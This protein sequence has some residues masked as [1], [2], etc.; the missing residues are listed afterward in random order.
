MLEIIN[1]EWGLLDCY[2]EKDN[3]KKDWKNRRLS[4]QIHPWIKNSKKYSGRS[5]LL[6]KGMIISK[7]WKFLQGKLEQV[8][9]L[10]SPPIK[11][12]WLHSSH[13]QAE[14]LNVSILDEEQIFFY[15]FQR[16]DFR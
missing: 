5:K 15:H 9:F 3:E 7:W 12:T 1:K 13:I 14:N 10:V 8:W 4:L 11:I 16:G 2:C 6:Q